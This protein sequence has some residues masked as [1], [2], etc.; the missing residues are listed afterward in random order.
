MHNDTQMMVSDKDTMCLRDHVIDLDGP[1]TPDPVVLDMVD[2]IGVNAC[3]AD[4]AKRY[5]TSTLLLAARRGKLRTELAEAMGID[6]ST[7]DDPNAE[8]ENYVKSFVCNTTAD[9]LYKAFE[10]NG[11]LRHDISKYAVSFNILSFLKIVS[12]GITDPDESY[13]D[14]IE[15]T[16]RI[17]G[18][19]T[20]REYETFGGL[21]PEVI[22]GFH[23]ILK[24]NLSKMHYELIVA[25]MGLRDG[26]PK[27]RQVVANM[28]G[29]TEQAVLFGEREVFTKMGRIFCDRDKANTA[30]ALVN[31][32]PN[33]ITKKNIS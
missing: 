4:Y 1:R 31:R 21:E 6:G 11:M 5:D 13:F 33:R 16:Q 25:R 32:E 24:W 2:V 18:L 14:V 19:M 7:E 23:R 22:E 3:A 26:R 20:N 9:E 29:L 28:L 10:K 30:I 17:I 27:S 15:N 12:N 8:R